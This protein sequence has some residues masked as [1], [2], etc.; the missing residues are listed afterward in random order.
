M[1]DVHLLDILPAPE[2]LRFEIKTG[3]P[4]AARPQVIAWLGAN[5]ME[6]AFPPRMIRSAYF[7][8]EDFDAL[9]AA[10]AGISDRIKPRLRWYGDTTCPDKVRFE[11]KC[12]R[13]HAGYKVID[14]IVGPIDIENWTWRRLRDEVRRQLRPELQLLLDTTNRPTV[15][16]HYNRSYYTSRDRQLRVT[17]DEHLALYPQHW[18]RPQWRRK[19]ILDP[20]LIVEVKGPV[21]LRARIARLMKT[22]LGRRSRLSKYGLA[23]EQ[24]RY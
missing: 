18:M 19:V 23:L 10:D 5:Q 6:V 9:E 24:A 11:A 17:L 16:N 13:G 21:A 8:T 4:L 20:V 3:L 7:D 14:N 15:C 12:R 22:A 2:E 1:A